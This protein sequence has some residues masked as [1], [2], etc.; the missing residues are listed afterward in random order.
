MA[1]TV[2]QLLSVARSQLGTKEP[3]WDSTPGGQITKYSRWYAKY[4][5]QSG[6]IDTY[7]C[8][9]FVSWCLAG[10]GFTVTEAGRF[11]NCNPHIAWWKAHGRWS[12]HPSPGAVVYFSWDGDGIA[13]HVGFVETVLPTGKLATIEGNATIGGG[14]HDGVYRMTRGRGAVVGFGLPPYLPAG[15]PAP[16]IAKSTPSLRLPGPVPIA[17]SGGKYG[18][19]D[20]RH[21]PW[22]QCPVMARGFGGPENAGQH[23]WAG[24]WFR[25]MA[26]FS[27]GYFT[28]ITSTAAGKAEVTRGEIGPVTIAAADAMAKQVL[29]TAYT[30]FR[31]VIP[32][33]AWR[34]YQPAR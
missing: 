16:A 27:P 1:A 15:T 17:A 14:A 26:A 30:P 12:A 8:E 31:G 29:G 25:L 22:Q 24:Y 9:M 21:V 32:A 20:A 34:V 7:W 33:A 19:A 2:A 10:A 6:Y 11:G 3:G 23:A 5:G 4:S 13:E 18:T 28:G